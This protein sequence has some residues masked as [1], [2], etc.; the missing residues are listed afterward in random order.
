MQGY[1]AIGTV[2]LLVIMVLLQVIILG[3]L[4][5]KTIYFGKLDKKDYIIIPFALLFFYIIFSSAFNLPKLGVELFS[6]SI[7]KWIGVVFSILGLTVF[8]LSIISIGQSFRVGIDLERQG[9][10]VTT[11]TFAVSRNPLYLAIIFILI[12]LFLIFPNWILLVYIVSGFFLFNRQILIEEAF[13]IKV[14]GKKY[15]EYCKKVPR[16]F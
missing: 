16:Y 3:N 9:N 10:L 6:M 11:G 1:F 4:G 12:G 14:Y 2:V 8:L 7:I 13:L 5:I 15:E